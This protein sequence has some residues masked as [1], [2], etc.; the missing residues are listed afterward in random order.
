MNFCG[1][2]LLVVGNSDLTSEN[3]SPNRIIFG[4]WES[5]RRNQGK[6]AEKM[7]LKRIRYLLEQ[8]KGIKQAVNELSLGSGQITFFFKV[9][10]KTTTSYSIIICIKSIARG[11][12]VHKPAMADD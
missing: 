11:A 6:Q 3:P 4:I 5:V 1:E 12:G 10:C 8:V 7:R 9:I 2:N